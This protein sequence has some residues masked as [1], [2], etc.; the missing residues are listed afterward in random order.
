MT[1]EALLKSPG[2]LDKFY[3]ILAYNSLIKTFLLL[4]FHVLGTVAV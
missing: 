1:T 4:A 2:M 3:S